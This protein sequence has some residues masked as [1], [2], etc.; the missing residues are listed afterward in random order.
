MLRRKPSLPRVVGKIS[1]SRGN[2]ASS[3]RQATRILSAAASP[4]KNHIISAGEVFG[5]GAI[6]EPVASSSS[7][8]KPDL[9]RWD[10]RKA[11]VG[12]GV[13]HGGLIYEAPELPPMLYLETP[14][15]VVCA[16]SWM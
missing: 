3:P 11:T 2:S 1:D 6:I 5:D 9:V 7:Q 12:S 4:T 15:R 14:V 10:G 16:D 8:N 13:E